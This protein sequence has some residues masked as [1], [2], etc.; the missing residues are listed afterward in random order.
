MPLQLKAEGVVL[1]IKLTPKASKDALIRLEND[2]DGKCYI[3]ASVTAVPEKGKANASLVKLLSKK[4][5]LPKTS[6]T[7]IAGDQARQKTVLITGDG[8]ALK[9][10]ITE[11]LM[12]LGLKI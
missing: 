1:H 2:A 7:L 8:D 6:I 3:K 4:L 9:N 12:V 5:G 11:K 10:I